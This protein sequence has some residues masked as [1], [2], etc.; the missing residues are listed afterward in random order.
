M[1]APDNT[2]QMQGAYHCGPSATW[3]GSWSL[4]A[5]SGSFEYRLSKPA[6]DPALPAPSGTY[7][8]H[9]T[10]E[11]GTRIDEKGVKIRLPKPPTSAADGEY[12]VTGSGKNVYGGFVLSGAM[13]ASD[14]KWSLRLAKVYRAVPVARADIKA[15]PRSSARERTAVNYAVLDLGS[16]SGSYVQVRL[17]VRA[18]PS[19]CIQWPACL[20][21]A[22]L[23]AGARR[24]GD[25][26]GL[27]GTF[28]PKPT[29][30]TDICTTHTL[31]I[32][33]VL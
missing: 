23:R 16:E 24:A 15:P 20:T 8:G 30:G 26:A 3:V 14:G 17:A 31:T 7:D 5:S 1:A 6:A 10:L 22:V 13:V 2:L 19:V 32:V 4:G 11:N 21:H 9:F 18:A 27:Q 33:A 25:A 29:M 12:T 28:R